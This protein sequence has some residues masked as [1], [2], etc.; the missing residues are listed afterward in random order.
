MGFATL[1]TSEM[2]NA[3]NKVKELGERI[4]YGNLMSIASALWRQKLKP[5]GT[6]SGAFIPALKNDIKQD[7]ELQK[8]IKDDIEFY[9][10]LVES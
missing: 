10:N 7:A 5:D 8:I 1:K 4:G 9:D 2:A 6:E 3:I